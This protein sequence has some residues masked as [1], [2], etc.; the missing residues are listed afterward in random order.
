MKLFESEDD[1][2]NQGNTAKDYII[3]YFW[4]ILAVL[5][6]VLFRG[7][8]GNVIYDKAVFLGLSFIIGAILAKLSY[9][10]FENAT[11]KV[12]YNYG[13]SITDGEI[14]PAGNFGI[15]RPAIKAYQWYFKL[16]GALVAPLD[17]IHKAGP[18]ILINARMDRVE[19]DELGIEARSIIKE[20]GIKPPYYL[21]FADEEQYSHV[22]DDPELKQITGLTKPD[23]NYL[24]DEI[25]KV[26]KQVSLRERVLRGDTKAIEEYVSG[27]SRIQSRAKGDIWDS[28]KK[29]ATQE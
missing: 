21:G 17:A 14:I 28:L 26:N 10:G 23:V 4:L 19:L 22:F 25:K 15:M 5:F 2:E 1:E 16:S 8:M 13:H 24:V 3:N 18:N 20:K 9:I 6:M 29:I 12:I 11:P 27:A 7:R